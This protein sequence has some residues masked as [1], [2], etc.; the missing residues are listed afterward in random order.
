MNPFETYLR[1][2]LE[3]H[4][5]IRNQAGDT[6][7]ADSLRDEMDKSYYQLHEENP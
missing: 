6:V 1:L 4:Y 7:Y 2:L 5:L 3:L